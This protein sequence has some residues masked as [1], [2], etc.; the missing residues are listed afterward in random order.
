[1]SKEKP[2]ILIL[3]QNRKARFNYFLSDFLEVGIELKGTE[4][5]SLRKNGANIGDAYITFK[6]GEAFVTNMHIAPY[7]MGNIFNHNPLRSRK[8]LMHKIEIRKY[9]AKVQEKGF[10]VLPSKVYL[11][12][13]KAKVEIA[14]G[15]GKNLYDKREVM[16]KRDVERDIEKTLKNR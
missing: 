15:K 8:L 1:M 16:K 3:A 4:I 13:G 10:T 7:E 11:K 6:N 5:K 14:L 9:Q 2:G 12:A